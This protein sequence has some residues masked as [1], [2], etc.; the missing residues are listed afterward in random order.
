MSTVAIQVDT[1][2]PGVGTV[3][4]RFSRAGR[5][6]DTAPLARVSF[7]EFQNPASS[8]RAAGEVAPR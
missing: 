3:S 7:P 8:C 2:G 6:M 4:D 5:A 1:R